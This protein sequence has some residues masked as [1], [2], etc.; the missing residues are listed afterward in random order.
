MDRFQSNLVC[1]LK[2]SKDKFYPKKVPNFLVPKSQK[3]SKFNLALF[4]AL[5]DSAFQYDSNAKK[6]IQKY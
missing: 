3:T 4:L 2:A 1:Y 5:N 6:I